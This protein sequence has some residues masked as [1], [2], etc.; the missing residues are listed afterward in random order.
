MIKAMFLAP[1][2]EQAK[3]HARELGFHNP[4]EW[5]FIRDI[6]DVEG[7]NLKEMPIYRVGG[8]ML[9]RK[10]KDVMDY[11]DWKGIEL[12]FPIQEGRYDTGE[13]NRT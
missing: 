8:F 11:L 12:I 5:K 10:K 1:T 9:D 6:Q 3:F 2:Y 7:F 13:Y 4:K